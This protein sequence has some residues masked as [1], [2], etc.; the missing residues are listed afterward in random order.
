MFS[1][2]GAK[3]KIVD[4]YPAPSPVYDTI[5]EPFAGSARYSLKYFEKNVILYE[6]YNKV[7]EVWKYLLSATEKDILELPDLKIG[8]DIRDFKSLS[9]AERWLI[10]YQLQ[11][12]NARPGCLVNA[13]CRW[14]TDKLKIAKEVH[15]I[16]HWKI[17][18]ESGLNH[19]WK[20]ATYFVDPPYMVQ[21][22][23]YNHGNIDY[24]L[25]ISQ[26]TTH[27]GQ[28]IVCGNS[29]DTWMDFKPLT[30][31][32][33]TAKSHIECMWTRQVTMFKD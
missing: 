5:V 28:F 33:G 6:T 19:E 29:E 30:V 11:R 21:K 17:Y 24:S 4:C 3:T 9:D 26:V 8:D 20:D 10:G 15:K 32:N 12:G 27:N 2:Y 1:Y 7:Y 13:R 25:I 16:K 31:M 14:N 22:H 18:N 23:G